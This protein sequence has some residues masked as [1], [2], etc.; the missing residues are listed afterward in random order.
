MHWCAAAAGHLCICWLQSLF[1]GKARRS[2]SNFPAWFGESP[3]MDLGA[4]AMPAWIF[5][6]E[7]MAQ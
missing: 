3:G 2:E 7:G 1:A 5:R 6:A 4:D